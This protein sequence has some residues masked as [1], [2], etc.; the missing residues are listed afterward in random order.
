MACYD[1]RRTREAQPNR[2]STTAGPART[3]EQRAAP[4]HEQHRK[5]TATRQDGAAKEEA[6]NRTTGPGREKPRATAEAERSGH[7]AKAAGKKAW[8]AEAKQVTAKRERW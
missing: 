1:M 6:Q 8:R 2:K 4:R 3:N 5:A 7:R